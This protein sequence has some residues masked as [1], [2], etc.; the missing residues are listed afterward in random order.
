RI[1][2]LEERPP[3]GDAIRLWNGDSRGHWES[4][5]LV[6]ETTHQNA[7]PWLDQRGR[8]FTEDARVVERLTLIEPDTIHYQATIDDPSVYMRDFTIALA[9]RRN[10]VEGQELLEE[11]CYENNGELMVI[12]RDL[13]LTIYP[14]IAPQAAREAME[15]ER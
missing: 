3:L 4:D 2:H 7:R 10:T 6:I 12:Y 5:T 14:G 11:S 13:G 8:F 15:A 1:V 9:Y